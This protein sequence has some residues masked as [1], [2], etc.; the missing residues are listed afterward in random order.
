MNLLEQVVGF[1]FRCAESRGL[2]GLLSGVIGGRSIRRRRLRSGRGRGRGSGCGR[3]DRRGD[4]ASSSWRNGFGRDQNFAE[5]DVLRLLHL[6]LVLVVELLDFFFADGEVAADFLADHLLGDDLVALVLL[7]V[8]PGDALFDRFFF[9][10]LHG[11][12]LHVLAHL[13]EV[14]DQ[15]GVAGNAKVFA[16]VEQELLVDEIAENVF[17]TLGVELVGILGILLFHFVPKLIFAAL[18]LRLGD[19]LVVDTGDDLFDGLP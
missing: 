10:V 8:F 17:F 9:Q 13:V 2:C 4:R 1:G 16:F 3:G 7:E 6:A 18:K 11:V 12:E 19:D 5:A 15:L 14:F